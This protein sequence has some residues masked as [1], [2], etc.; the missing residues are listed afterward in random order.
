[1]Q[2]TAGTRRV[3]VE[4]G[5]RAGPLGGSHHENNPVPRGGQR[6]ADI[7]PGV[8]R[9]TTA[10]W[11]AGMSELD[12]QSAVSRFVASRLVYR[13]LGRRAWLLGIPV[14]AALLVLRLPLALLRPA[15]LASGVVLATTL[16]VAVVELAVLAGLAAVSLRQVWLAFS[17]RAAGPKDLNESAR[18]Q[19]RE[20]VR[21][22][23]AGLVRAGTCRAE[24]SPQSGGFYANPG[25]CCEVVTEAV[26]RF[27]GLGLPSPFLGARCAGWVELEA[28]NELHAR[29]L[30]GEVAL[31]GATLAERLLARQTGGRANAHAS[32]G[33]PKPV[34]IASFPHGSAWPAAL[35]YRVKHRGARRLAAVVVAAAGF[36]SLVS[37]MSQPLAQR[38]AVLRRL[39]PLAVP[40]A[41]G[42]LAAL[43]GIALLVL[44][45]G[46]RR[47]Q[48]RAF[49]VCQA[50]LV[51]VAVLHLVRAVDVVSAAV[52]LGVVGFLWLNRA[53]FKA[54]SDNPPLWRGL[55]TL[56]AV[57]ALAVVAAAFALEGSYKLSVVVRH[58]AAGISWGQAFLATIER[59]GGVRH[60]PLP[61][62]L[63][64]F[65]S[66]AMFAVTAGLVLVAVWMVFRPVVGHWPRPGGGLERARE[67]VRRH[68]SGT[69]DYFALRSDKQFFFWGGTV[70]AYAVYSGTCLV[71]PDPVGPVVERERA[72]RAF[73]DFAD[74]RGW[75]LRCWGRGR[76]GSRSTGRP[77]CTI[78]TSATRRSSGPSA[79]SWREAGSRASARRSEG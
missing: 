32:Q 45:R 53:S 63:D 1:M 26:P 6:L 73:R 9:G 40:Q 47:G 59:M 56:A 65:F 51:A 69:L 28:G 21:S 55:A 24:L 25:C 70:V 10:G 60:V 54:G 11:L 41:A 78:S 38:L 61:D 30:H 3:R 42:A 68:G 29:L 39:L 22:G 37:S 27:G 17:G 20:L 52:A 7:V 58:R 14:L 74:A 46:I 64:D 31:A 2:V 77:A 66:P 43:A 18:A 5:E 57:A 4:P 72:W 49:L 62:R 44:A 16:A 12:D 34:V 19:S 35:S 8:W 76:I 75:P 48:R 15:R 50:T 79:S 71:S 67:V 23:W 33:R 36:L 13:Q